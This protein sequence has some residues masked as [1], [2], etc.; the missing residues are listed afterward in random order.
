[1]ESMEIKDKKILVTGGAGFIGSHLVNALINQGAKV[2]VIDIKIEA[3]SIFFTQN[4]KKKASFTILDIRNKTKV[5]EYLNKHSPEYIFHLAAEPIVEKAFDN[6]LDTF[7]TNIIG[8]VN[9]LEVVRK[10]NKIKGIIVASSDKAYGKTKKEY[11]EES[12]LKGDHPYDVSKS[13]MD[14]ICQT[15][16]KT[17]G[18]PIVI[19]RFGNVYGEG[20][21]NSSRIIPGICESIIKNKILN[22]RSDGSY[23]RDYLYVKDVVSG[24]IFLLKNFSK[25]KGEAYNFSSKDTLSVIDLIIK[26][27]KVLGKKIPYK[28]I[29]NARNEIPYQ[30]LS[31]IKV[32]KLG[33]KNDYDLKTSLINVLDWY[34][35]LL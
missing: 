10:N 19:T 31:D 2:S 17:Y 9:L 24:Y 25:T 14:L 8:T 3:K 20:D 7:Q 35:H 26:A 33:W 32:R 1:M 22:I 6:P 16:Y 23:V 11:T 27:E 5:K 12:P 13:C 4:L 29:N 34:S 18:T 21:A 30:H 15:Y 28:I